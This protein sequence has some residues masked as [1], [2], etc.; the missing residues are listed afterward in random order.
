[1]YPLYKL[2]ILVLRLEL[3]DALNCST[4]CNNL[5]LF[6]LAEKFII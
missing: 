6:F 2:L 5:S 3:V 1:M 4:L